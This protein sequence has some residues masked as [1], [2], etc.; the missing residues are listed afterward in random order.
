M[1]GRSGRGGSGRWTPARGLLALGVGLLL[2]APG[3][4]AREPL[5]TDRPDFTESASSVAPGRIQVEAGVEAASAGDDDGWE[6]GLLVRMGLGGGWE[7]RLD[8]GAYQVSEGAAGVRTRGRGDGSLGVKAELPSLGGAEA[9]LI[10]AAELP[11]GTSAV[12]E[13]G[14]RPGAVLALARDLGIGSREVGLG[15]NLG[16][17]RSSDDG[18]RFDQLSA[19]VAAGLDLG[20]RAG[21][22]VEWF[23]FRRE[24][25][26]G[27]A[28]HYLDGG[29]TWAL[30]PDLQLDLYAGAGLTSEATDSF[31]GFGLSG[32]F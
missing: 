19:S 9:A 24:E 13:S 28:T 12:G 31:V 27:G 26:G 6:G 21:I 8:P 1:Q 23:G 5:V 20:D 7:L 17:L 3:T 25:P 32:R 29:V 4:A 14:V 15:A 2:A 18:R 11:T 16:Y 22:F 30:G 10:V